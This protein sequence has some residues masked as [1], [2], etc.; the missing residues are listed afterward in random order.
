[1]VL[2]PRGIHI[3]E[4]NFYVTAFYHFDTTP[5]GLTPPL[6]DT[7]R[8][9]HYKTQDALSE[10][11]LWLDGTN[12]FI[13]NLKNEYTVLT[14]Y[15]N[16]EAEFADVGQ[17]LLLL[18]EPRRMNRNTRGKFVPERCLQERLKPTG[19]L[20][21][22]PPITQ[23]NMPT[24]SYTFDIRPDCSYWVSLAGF[25]LKW[26]YAVESIVSIH[27]DRQGL[28]CPYLTVEFKKDASTMTNTIDQVATAGSL[29]LYNRYLLR[30]EHLDKVGKGY[31]EK[32]WRVVRRYG[33]TFE[34]SKFKIWCI[35]PTIDYTN[36]TWHGCRMVKLSAGECTVGGGSIE[37]LIDWLNEVHAW[38]LK[39]HGPAC[40]YDVKVVL[41]R[42][43]GAPRTSLTE[44]ELERLSSLE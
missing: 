3:D 14:F 41:L 44:E 6:E 38:G 10:T 30:K 22:E 43:R 20:W 35:E 13:N 24:R 27:R 2:A 17:Q 8:S 7:P 32:K 33:L 40:M 12:N 1:M 36:G 16:S 39:V 15:W 42:S 34:G 9:L 26:S 25:S 28:L 21:V 29:A 23:P 5:L 37:N 18:K 4:E 31:T 11:K 19:E